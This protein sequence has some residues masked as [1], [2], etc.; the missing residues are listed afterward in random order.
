MQFQVFLKSRQADE[1][2][3][4]RLAHLPDVLK[5]QMI[6]NESFDLTGVIVRESEFPTDPLGHSRANVNVPVE[7]DARARSRSR[8]KGWRLPHVMQ[9]HAPSQCGGAIWRKHFQ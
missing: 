4:R 2:L 8:R 3:E 1:S 6:R 7:P 9:Q 5:A